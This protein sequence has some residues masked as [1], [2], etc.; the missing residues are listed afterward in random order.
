M[1]K[2]YIYKKAYMS[3]HILYIWRSNMTDNEMQQTTLNIEKNLHKRT[4]LW[5]YKNE[6]TVNALLVGLLTEH[7]KGR[8]VR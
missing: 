5:C 6:T 4:K 8:R 2:L 3:W 7:M 1:M